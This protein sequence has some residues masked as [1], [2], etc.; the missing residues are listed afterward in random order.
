M[1]QTLSSSIEYISNIQTKIFNKQSKT[2]EIIPI[3]NFGRRT[4]FNGLIICLTSLGELIDDVLK[5]NQMEFILTYTI[6]QDHLEMFFSA[7]RSRGG[8]CDNPTASQF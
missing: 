7:I 6:S 1:S 4:G 5:T 8:F 2:H 3:I